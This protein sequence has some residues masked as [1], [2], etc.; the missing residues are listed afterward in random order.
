MRK[1]LI[2][3][4]GAA[5]CL[6]AATMPASAITLNP[7]AMRP[8]IDAVAN[9]VDK[10]WYRY[11]CHCYRPHYSYGYRRYYR[12][13]YGYGYRRYYRPYYGYAYRRYYRPYYAYGYRPYY[14]PYYGYGYG[15]NPYSYGFGYGYSPY[16]YGYA[17]SPSY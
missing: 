8:A 5:A 12:P 1:I 17:Y 7:G 9:S 10:A 14:R 4:I 13:Y 6:T 3:F 11:G 15:Y 2:A 16:G